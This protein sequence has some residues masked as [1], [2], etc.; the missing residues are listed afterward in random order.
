MQERRVLM[1]SYTNS[2]KQKK[3]KVKATKVKTNQNENDS[4]DNSSQNKNDS[5]DNPI[6]NNKKLQLNK[7]IHILSIIIIMIGTYLLIDILWISP[8]KSNKEMKEIQEI[9]G[10]N[11]SIPEDIK[12]PSIPKETD[13]QL[14]TAETSE[15]IPLEKFN[16]LLELNPDVKGWIQI[17]GT[18]INYPV[19]QSSK[20][21]PEYYLTRNMKKEDD[22]FGSIFLDTNT[23]I[24]TPTQCF[25]IHGH[26]MTSTGNMFHELMNYND[27]DFLINSPIIQFDTLY[28]ESL[29]K[30]FAVFKTNGS[31]AKEELFDYQRGSFQDSSDFLNFIYQIK[32]RSIY[33]IPLEISE[34]DQLLLLSTCSYELPNYRTV[35]VARKLRP[36]ES[37]ELSR[38]SVTKNKNPIYPDSWYHQYG[39]TPPAITTFEE[40]QKNHEI[41]WYQDFTRDTDIKKAE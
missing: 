41:N 25:L 3:D 29:W 8:T 37:K 31:S 11:N 1:G 13:D 5:K 39:G 23:D 36:G 34:E 35:I 17:E 6:R 26:N 14:T 22:R 7:A 27:L 2:I 20:D 12:T 38:E 30:I 15:I 18:N 19:L 33:N 16:H 10:N 40:A 9:Y 32:V 24:E 28:E 21:E 4:K